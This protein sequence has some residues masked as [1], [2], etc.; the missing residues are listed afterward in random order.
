[1]RQFFLLLLLTALLAACGQPKQ[2]TTVEAT[3]ADDCTLVLSV[4]LDGFQQ[5]TLRTLDGTVI[6]TLC[7]EAATDSVVVADSTLL[8]SIA[9]LR[10]EN[11]ADSL[12]IMEMPVAL[13][14]GVVK[15]QIGEYLNTAGTPTNRA[16]QDFLNDMQQTVDGVR[17]NVSLKAADIPALFSAF[18]KQQILT[19]RKN[20]LAPY[21]YR[22]Y[23]E[24]LTEEDRAL[25]KAEMGY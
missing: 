14:K 13:E 3:A 11:P 15:V 7:A 1:M 21:I 20:A 19:N 16:I 18:Y 17:S 10:L 22:M 24:Q 5:T 2:Q 8:G 4:T 6:D 23:G 25:V 12:D 9:L